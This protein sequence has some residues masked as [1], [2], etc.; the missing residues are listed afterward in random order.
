MMNEESS[1]KMEE[2]NNGHGLPGVDWRHGMD[3]GEGRN[4]T[5]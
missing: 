1:Y 2:W 5:A 4:E 3:E